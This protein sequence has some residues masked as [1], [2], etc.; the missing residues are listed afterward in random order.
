MEMIKVHL[1][2]C[3]ELY[4]ITFTNSNITAYG[5][6]RVN[7]NLE[8][9]YRPAQEQSRAQWDELI[10]EGALI[11]CRIHKGFHPIALFRVKEM[12]EETFKVKCQI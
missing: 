9:M 4:Q 8:C 2:N 11:K 6:L 12:C 5:K 1:E 10:Y 7:Y 3:L